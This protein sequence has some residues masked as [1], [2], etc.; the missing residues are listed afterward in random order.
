MIFL[1][2]LIIA[3]CVSQ[4]DA[5]ELWQAEVELTSEPAGAQVI[6]FNGGNSETGAGPVTLGTTPLTWE[7]SRGLVGAVDSIE[8]VFFKPGHG[9]TTLE[10]AIDELRA[11]APIAAVIPAFGALEITSSPM[12]TFELS[13]DAGVGV[14]GGDYAPAF[15]GELTP[16]TYT[17]TSERLGYESY[18]ATVTVTPG[19]RTNHLVELQPIDGP[20][21]GEPRMSVL[22]GAVEGMDT[23]AFYEAL[24]GQSRNV[25]NCIDR[26]MVGDPL[27]AG[28][29]T[30]H[31]ALNLPFGTVHSAEIVE[32]E[33]EGAEAIDC[34]QRRLRRVTYQ[35]VGGE[36]DMGSADVILR[37]HRIAQ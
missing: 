5:P 25:A 18:E 1:L 27:A 24:R 6:W 8:L 32:S 23:V 37:Y 19:A 13:D 16:G 21:D 26:A 2:P 12:A 30:V 20:P 15:V 10:V 36:G 33:I 3:S 34:I 28:L 4:A 14:S 35:A 31:M 17:L 11:D 22:P 29:V 7:A 9:R